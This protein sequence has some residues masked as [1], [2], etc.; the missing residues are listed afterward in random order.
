MRNIQQPRALA[1]REKITR[2]AAGLFALKG[3]HDTTLEEVRHA[4]EV[5]T[6]AFLTLRFHATLESEHSLMASW[7]RRW[8]SMLA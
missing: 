6:G 7:R 4:A 3:Y 2:A 1:T 5:T 8:L